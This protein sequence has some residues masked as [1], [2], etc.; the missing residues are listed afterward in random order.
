MKERDIMSPAKKTKISA[1]KT[2][3]KKAPANKS[4][5][6]T[7]K[8][9]IPVVAAPAMP[10]MSGKP[11]VAAAKVEPKKLFWPLLFVALA[12]GFYLIKDELIVATVNGRPITRVA[13]IRE[14]E[15]QGAAQVVEDIV[16]RTLVEQ[17]LKKAGIEIDEAAVEEEITAIEEQLSA[18]GQ[19]LDDLLAAQSLTREEVKQQIGLSKGM[20]QLLA[21]G[22][23]VSEEE[24]E[25]YFNENQE[26]MGEGA[27]LETM[28]EDIRD[29][30]LQQQL[31]QKQQEWINELKKNAKINYFKFK[32]SLNL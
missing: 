14:L 22:L 24:I 6:A 10:V 27:D 7:R 18:Q 31:G 13:V 1:V 32:P 5:I 15:R 12:L 9:T 23:T 26:M 16:L 11:V 17:E 20:E 4:K 28:R 25:A 30:L 8:S 21:D 2:V 3:A 29:M 19:N